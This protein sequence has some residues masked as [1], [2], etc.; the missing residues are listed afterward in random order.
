METRSPTRWNLSTGPDWRPGEELNEELLAAWTSGIT[1][2]NFIEMRILHWE[3][4]M[5]VLK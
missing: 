3:V 5:E 2:V 4:E 1:C